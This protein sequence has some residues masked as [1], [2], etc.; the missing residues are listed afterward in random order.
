MRNW[1]KFGY[2]DPREK[3]HIENIHPQEMLGDLQRK[4][5]QF[6]KAVDDAVLQDWYDKTKMKYGPTTTVSHRLVSQAGVGGLGVLYPLHFCRNALPSVAM[7]LV[8][9]LL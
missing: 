8:N 2:Q 1:K 3:K 7:L 5:K 9:Y 6:E 4:F